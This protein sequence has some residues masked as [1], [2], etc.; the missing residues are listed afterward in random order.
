MQKHFYETHRNRTRILIL[1]RH[2]DRHLMPSTS[3]DL[4]F[5]NK[6][7]ND[8]LIQTKDLYHA[9]TIFV[10]FPIYPITGL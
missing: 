2:I 10:M 8:N 3:W 7:L 1:S 9:I 5:Q 6:K 4:N